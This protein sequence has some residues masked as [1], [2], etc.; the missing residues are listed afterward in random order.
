MDKIIIYGAGGLGKEIAFLINY[1]NKVKKSWKIIG[2]IDDNINK[3][4]E[5]FNGYRVLGTGEFLE[6][7]QTDTFVICAIGSGSVRQLL[8]SEMAHYDNIL[9]P[10]LIDPTVTIDNSIS[11]TNKPYNVYASL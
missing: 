6:E 7:L 4:I 8:Y 10:T 5:Y 1:I 11:M 3:N 2:Y 9:I